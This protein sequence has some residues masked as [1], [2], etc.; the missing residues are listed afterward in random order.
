MSKYEEENILHNIKIQGAIKRLQSQIKPV[1][2]PI[3][4]KILKRINLAQCLVSAYN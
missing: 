1:E 2:N 3:V 4:A